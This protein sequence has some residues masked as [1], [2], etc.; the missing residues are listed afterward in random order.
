MGT[1]TVVGLGPEAEIDHGVEAVE[2]WTAL[3]ARSGSA[4]VGLVFD[5]SPY[6]LRDP[7]S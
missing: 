4:S 2:F 5:S 6:A 7:S 3:D 1:F